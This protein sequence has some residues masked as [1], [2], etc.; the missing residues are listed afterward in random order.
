[1]D[2]KT[3]FRLSV[4]FAAVYFFSINGIAAVSN[5]SLS[6]LLKEGVR[7]TPSEASYFQAVT[8][9]AWVIKPLWGYLSDTCPL[10]GYRRK[11]Y[12]I[13]SA[14]FAAASWFFLGI[15]GTF[16]V[17][18]LLF[19]IT[20]AYMAYAFQD[21]VTDAYMVEIGQPANMTGRFQS[22]QWSA[23]YL[24]MTVTALAGGYLADQI[25][26]GR[27]TYQAVFLISAV[28][29]L[30][31]LWVTVINVK[32]TSSPPKERSPQYFR[33]AFQNK[34]VWLLCA[35]LFLWTFSPSFGPAFFYYSVDTLKFS[36]SF[37][38]IVQACAAVTAFLTSLA[39]G[40]WIDRIPMRK[41]FV[42][43]VYAGV[44][45]LLFHMIYFVPWFTS[46]PDLL[47]AITLVTRVPF[48]FFDTIVFLML[49][50]LAAKNVPP[51]AGGS[52]FALFMSFYN[53]GQVGSG[54]LGGMMLPWAGLQNLMLISAGF[55]CLVFFV[56]PFLPIDEKLTRTE[57]FF[58]RAVGF[59]KAFGRA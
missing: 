44:A 22:I 9:I 7:L 49:A 37:L 14:F 20:S 23:V 43:A 17:G 2:S 35:F 50:N 56:L 40:R 36:G 59:R 10:G 52:V 53:L 54:I 57:K 3:Q 27:W 41:T 19:W 25:R 34:S 39:V 33:S 12:L 48:S 28:F 30:L 46:R 42:I 21:V 32:E 11:P 4:F 55:S 51:E 18:W 24:A 15:T 8:L 6:F 16:T 31:T 45:I 58:Q 1:M 26:S 47:K 38:G 29:P 13:L 5:L